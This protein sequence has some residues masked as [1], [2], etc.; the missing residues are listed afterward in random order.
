M[1]DSDI[2]LLL[3]SDVDD[4]T[5]VKFKIFDAF[6]SRSNGSSVE[7]FF[8]RLRRVIGKMR[9]EFEY[10]RETQIKRFESSIEYNNLNDVDNKFQ[11]ND[12]NLKQIK[13][14][15]SEEFRF[16]KSITCY[17]LKNSNNIE[18]ISFK[19]P[20]FNSLETIL[21]ETKRTLLESSKYNTKLELNKFPHI[22]KS[23]F[24]Y[25][26]FRDFH[27]MSFVKKTHHNAN[28]SF[29]FLELESRDTL[30]CSGP[31]FIGFLLETYGI[32][33]KKIDYRKF[34]I[35]SKMKK[36]DSITDRLLLDL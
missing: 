17:S 29:I 12:F 24:S 35:P 6:N 7:S 19:Y 15:E 13:L 34:K 3:F 28:Y 1:Q 23:D 32:K 26:V 18:V 22:F 21:D 8:Y 30:L 5:F 36:F 16:Y 10:S 14:L 20:W 4:K 25:C 11:M 27:E 9:E 31:E 2:E 33:I